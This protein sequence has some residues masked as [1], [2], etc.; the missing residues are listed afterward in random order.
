MTITQLEH[1]RQK[2]PELM[3]L[4]AISR[5]AG[6][7]IRPLVYLVG[8]VGL[9]P[10]KHRGIDIYKFEDVHEI[11]AALD[12]PPGQVSVRMLRSAFDATR[13]CHRCCQRVPKKGEEHACAQE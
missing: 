6:V 3:T 12:I 1:P 7:P 2:A 5:Q 9:V 11:L 4:T 13:V 8:Q 10:A